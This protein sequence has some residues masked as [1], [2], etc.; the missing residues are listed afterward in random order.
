MD[1]GETMLCGTTAIGRAFADSPGQQPDGVGCD[2]GPRW[3]G[4]LSWERRGGVGEVP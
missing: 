1:S 3:R 2:N 4:G